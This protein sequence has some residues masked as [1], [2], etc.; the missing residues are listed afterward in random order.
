MKFIYL[1]GLDKI[2][3]I[4]EMGKKVMYLENDYMDVTLH[5]KRPIKWMIEDGSI[6]LLH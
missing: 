4:K 6:I 2:Y 5:T 1:A 3:Q